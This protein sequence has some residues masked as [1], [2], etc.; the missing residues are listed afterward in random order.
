MESPVIDTPILEKPLSKNLMGQLVD[1]FVTPW[2]G[3]QYMRRNPSLWKYAFWPI[4]L[5]I[6]IMA[7]VFIAMIFTAGGL[8]AWVTSMAAERMADSGALAI[9]AK[10]IFFLVVAI[11]C[12]L[13]GVL[14]W[15][16]LANIF[17]GAL[18]GKLADRVEE[19]LGLQDR[20]ELS[21]FQEIRDTFVNLFLLIAG[22]GAIFLLNFLPVIGSL[23]ALLLSWAF[24]GFLLGGQRSN[25]R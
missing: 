9:G 17:C 5:N 23:A 19:M 1:G 16:I 4:V 3:F 12:G 18:Y 15:Y 11:A 22:N 8:Y 2:H 14:I 25:H 6:L 24:T 13:L 10:I 21:T 20:Q 7:A